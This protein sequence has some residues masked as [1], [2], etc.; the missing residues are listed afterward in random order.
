MEKRISH[1]D[2]AANPN[3]YWSLQKVLRRLL[4]HECKHMYNSRQHFGLE[5]C[6]FEKW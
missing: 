5:T 4:E 6:G 3:E 1:I 2:Y